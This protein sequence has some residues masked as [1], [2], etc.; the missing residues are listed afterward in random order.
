MKFLNSKYAISALKNPI[1]QR[2]H[3]LQC[4]RDKVNVIVYDFQDKNVYYDI[5]KFDDLLHSLS[6]KACNP[7]TNYFIIYNP[8]ILLRINGKITTAQKFVEKTSLKAYSRSQQDQGYIKSLNHRLSAML[9]K[10]DYN[11]SIIK[12]VET[13]SNIDLNGYL[14]YYIS[15]LFNISAPIANEARNYTIMPN[16]IANSNLY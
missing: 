3:V 6:G 15:D 16:R 11:Y 8:D 1:Y 12:S 7:K 4:F 2:L 13:I 9:K 10:S 14:P 5:V